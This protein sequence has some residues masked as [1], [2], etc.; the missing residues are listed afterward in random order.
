VLLG[1]RT[2]NVSRTTNYLTSLLLEFGR[3]IRSDVVLFEDH[4]TTDL[5][6]AGAS[7]RRRRPEEAMFDPNGEPEGDHVVDV[8]GT[9]VASG[10]FLLH[11]NPPFADLYMETQADARRFGYASLLLKE[12]KKA[13][14]ETRRVPAARTSLDN[15]GSRA[16]LTKEGMRICGFMLPADVIAPLPPAPK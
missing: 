4:A 10:G 3:N 13:C 9:I 12:V 11:Y 8:E 16:A 15:Y 1:S 5:V 2:L 6:V 7:V 14:Y